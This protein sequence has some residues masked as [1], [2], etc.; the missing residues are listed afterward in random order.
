MARNDSRRDTAGIGPDPMLTGQLR[1]MSDERDFKIASGEP[2]IRGWEVRTLAGAEVGKVDDLLIDVHRGEV[3]MIDI[4]LVDSDANI[5]LP[6][7]GVQV[8]RARK[9]VVVDSGDIRSAREALSDTM[10]GD[11]M[12]DAQPLMSDVR[13]ADATLPDDR[14]VVEEVV[15]RRRVVDPGEVTDV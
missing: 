13:S 1:R 12:V 7:R 2:D 6:I 15:V 3:V 11:K 10:V 8:D 14:T 4:D 9:C 5:S